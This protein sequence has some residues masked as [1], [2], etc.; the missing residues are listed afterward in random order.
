LRTFKKYVSPHGGWTLLNNPELLAEGILIFQ[1][2][3]RSEII[4]LGVENMDHLVDLE[5][6]KTILGTR[7][8]DK[9]FGADSSYVLNSSVGHLLE[10]KAM[11]FVAQ[12][13]DLFVECP[14]SAIKAVSLHHP[15]QVSDLNGTLNENYRRL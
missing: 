1:L 8:S 12:N 2:G 4:M 14:I 7:V 11:M 6:G 13:P 9:Q 10:M 3:R 15:Q 5:K